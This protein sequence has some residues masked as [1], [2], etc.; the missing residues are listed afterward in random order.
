MTNGDKL[1]GKHEKLCEEVRS[2]GETLKNRVMSRRVARR[3]ERE[4]PCGAPREGPRKDCDFQELS[5]M[6]LRSQ[7]RVSPG[8]RSVGARR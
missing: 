7:L 3:A 2:L 8:R 6:V 5:K 4:E 1:L